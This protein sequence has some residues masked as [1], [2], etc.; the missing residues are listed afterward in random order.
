MGKSSSSTSSS[1]VTTNQDNRVLSEDG[2][3][4]QT[5]EGEV[6]ITH[7]ADG[8][9]ELATETVEGAFALAGATVANSF[10]SAGSG[11]IVLPDAEG[12]PLGVGATGVNAPASSIGGV[13]TNVILAVAAVAAVAVLARSRP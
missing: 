11:Q 5:I 3:A 4:A 9:I 2:I 10:G 7:T 12:N 1:N 13:S 6:V 8:A